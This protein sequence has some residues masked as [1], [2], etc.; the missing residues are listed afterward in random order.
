[1]N[2]EQCETLLFDLHE[3]KLEA[4]VA[5]QVDKHLSSCNECAALL[6]DIWQ[7]GIVSTR[8]QDQPLPDR[9]PFSDERSTK[10]SPQRTW[11]LP[12]IFA[13]AVS[14]LAMVV[15]LSDARISK[16]PEGI[17]LSFG[18]PDYVSTAALTDFRNELDAVFSQRFERLTTQ[19]IASNQ[20]VLRSVLDT[21]RAERRREITT[22]VSYWNTAQS[23]LIE[24]REEDLRYLLANQAED[25]KDINQLNHALQ[26]LDLRRGNNL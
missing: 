22:L 5:S 26:N 2:C 23:N 1:M 11:Q 6:N 14:V 24:Q 17:T 16:V 10:G 19:Q 3:G 15:V 4:N 9:T 25:E 21:S 13:T 20:L 7:M 18:E 8:W 12:Q